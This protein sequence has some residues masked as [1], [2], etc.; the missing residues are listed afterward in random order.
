MAFK[1]SLLERITLALYSILW[2]VLAPIYLGVIYGKKKH[3]PGCY[4]ATLVERFGFVEKCRAFKRKTVMIHCASLGEVNTAAPL[5][6]QLCDSNLHIIVTT[7]SK[8]GSARVRALFDKA[9]Q[10]FYLPID[11]PFAMSAMLTRTQ[12]DLV[13]LVEVELWP[14]LIHQCWRRQIPVV[15]INARMTD[16]SAERMA[17]FSALYKPVLA[18]L[19]H[20]CAQGKRDY[21]NYLTLGLSEQHL[22]LTNNLKFDLGEEASAT[23]QNTALF[24][25][26]ERLT[27]VAASTHEGEEEALLLSKIKLNSQGLDFRLILVPRH[28]ERFDAVAGWLH[29]QQCDFVRSTSVAQN[30][31]GKVGLKTNPVIL[32]DEMGKLNQ[33]YS[34][35]DI[36]F[37]GGSLVDKGGHNALEAAFHGLPTVMGP[38]TY[39]N[40]EI[41]EVLINANALTVVQNES[42]LTQVLHALLSE[43]LARAE[44][45]SAAKNAIKTNSGASLKTIKALQ[46]YLRENNAH[47]G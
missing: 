3:T 23:T 17:Q 28:P 4:R 16:K 35:S 5:I 22:T 18:K 11:L 14:N 6:R 24:D 46:V 27:L 25:S 32:V 26:G 2:V 38:Y 45:A 40:P 13:V 7:S 29:K 42:E 12:A 8:T 1:P 47:H 31:G 41:C 44:Q 33:M 10:H 21:Q 15:Q 36:A 34:M 20:V 39:N 19:S 30:A 9:V 37:V 43:P